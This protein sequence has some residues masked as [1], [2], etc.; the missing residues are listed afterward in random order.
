MPKKRDR[1]KSKQPPTAVTAR[2]VLLRHDMAVYENYERCTRRIF[3]MLQR[4]QLLFPGKPRHLWIS[5]QGHRND[6]GGFDHDAHEVIRNF[7]LELMLP[8][9][10]K[11]STPLIQASNSGRQCND[12]PELYEITYP[13]N[14][15]WYDIEQLPLRPREYIPPERKSPPSAQRIAE[16]LGTDISCLICWGIP[17]ERA[18][19]VPASLGGST[20]VRNFALLCPD[21][22]SQ[23]P[24][25]ADA[26]A[27][28]AWVDYAE[29]RDSGSK[30][31]TAP[32]DVRE[33]VRSVGGRDS[34][35]ERQELE[36]L[37]A[38]R[39]ELEHLYRWAPQD[40]SEFSWDLQ[41]EYHRVLEVATGVHFGVKKKPSTHAWAYHIA[42]LRLKS[43][44]R[45]DPDHPWSGLDHC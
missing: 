9:L 35:R 26:E 41:L 29:M 34:P 20:D 24:D 39:F 7:A 40:F 23:A 21:H 13:D 44:G 38:V 36:F 37:A 19:V 3:Q 18:H 10:S 14:G 4:T 2:Q 32:D 16:Y 42:K 43:R 12:V 22:H 17:A 33:W 5:V 27:F 25:I 45:H 6:A 8:Y 1:R 11:V 15:F 31:R 30:W 28:W